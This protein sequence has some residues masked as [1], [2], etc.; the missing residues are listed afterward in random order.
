VGSLRRGPL[1]LTRFGLTNAALTINLAYSGS[2]T[3]ALP[4]GA[5]QIGASLAYVGARIDTDFDAFPARR[6]RLGDYWLGS[7][8][9]A[10]RLGNRIELYSRM[11]N[12]FAADYQD[13]VGYATAGR[14]VYAGI[15]LRRGD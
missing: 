2:A 13:V 3:L 4:L 6:V 1:S 11:E 7:L 12:A 8:N 10:W 14:T 5:V 9:L 15:R